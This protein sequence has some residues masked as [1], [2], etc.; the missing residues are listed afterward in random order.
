MELVR[1]R[2]VCSNAGHD[3]GDFQIIMNFDEKY[4]I[5]CDGKHRPM[6]RMKRKKI[7]HVRPTN[8]VVDEKDLITNES[9]KKVLKDFR[10]LID[11]RKKIS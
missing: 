11:Y 3:K 7:I 4:V 8:T 10:A 5:L 9:I 1:G 2:I 6:E